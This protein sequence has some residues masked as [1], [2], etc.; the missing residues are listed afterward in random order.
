MAASLNPPRNGEGD[1]AKH[2]GGVDGLRADPSATT[3]RAAVPLPVPG[4]NE[5][6]FTLVELMVVIV[7][8]G[9]LA[10]IVIINVVPALDTA[11]VQKARTDIQTIDGAVQ[12]YYVDNRRYPTTQEGLAELRPYLRRVS[13]DPWS[14]PY[15]YAAPGRNGQPYTIM[16]LGA[17]GHE[18]GSGKDADIAN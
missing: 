10:T 11:S 17:D 6:G 14:R 5:E 1:R 3:L 8:L 18:G 9:L 16:S 4:R 13:N 12:Q 7:I 2:G 15:V